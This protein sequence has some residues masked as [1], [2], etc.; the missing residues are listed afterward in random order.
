MKYTKK[1]K[2]N[3]RKKMIRIQGLINKIYLQKMKCSK[4]L[5]LKS[6]LMIMI[7]I[8]LDKYLKI[9]Y[10]IKQI[11]AKEFLKIQNKFI[12]LKRKRNIVFVNKKKKFL[13][14]KNY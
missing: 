5:K 11:I 9:N 10:M 2:Y 14:L 12:N 7:M 4:Y 8:I 1:F 3:L 6:S 13:P